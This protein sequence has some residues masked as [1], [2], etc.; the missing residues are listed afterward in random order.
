MTLDFYLFH[1]KNVSYTIVYTVY[2]SF[3][4]FLNL[5]L[6]QLWIFLLVPPGVT[7]TS[8]IVYCNLTTIFNPASLQG[9]NIVFKDSLKPQ[10]SSIY[11]RKCIFHCYDQRTFSLDIAGNRLYAIR[12]CNGV[13]CGKEKVNYICLL[14]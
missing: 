11:F 14:S 4:I 1:F 9:Y 10:F 13:T 12:A 6:S 2:K 3:I 5:Y 8:I 7:L